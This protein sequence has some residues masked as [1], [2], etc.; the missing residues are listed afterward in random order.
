MSP[1]PS[2][3]FNHPAFLFLFVLLPLFWV[4]QR[5]AFRTFASFLGLLLH[6]LVLA[7]LVFAAAGLHM[8]GPGVVSTPLLVLDL[9]HSLTPEQRQWMRDTIVQRLRPAP[10]T[11][12][13]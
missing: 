3:A 11:P 9:S 8:L 6:S 1:L 2:L 5:R 13:R 10:D 7:L 12:R 4:W